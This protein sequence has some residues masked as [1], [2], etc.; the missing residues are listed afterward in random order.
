MGSNK[1]VE[2]NVFLQKLK[3]FT[4]DEYLLHGTSSQALL[5]KTM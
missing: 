5:V 2:M 3:Q 1:L 4:E